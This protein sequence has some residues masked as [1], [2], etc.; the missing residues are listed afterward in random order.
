V[1]NFSGW[2]DE[3]YGPEGATTNFAGLVAAR[4]GE[5]NARTKLVMGPWVH[6]GQDESKAGERDFGP[7]APIDYDEM[8]L[9]WMDRYVRGMD[10]GVDREKPVRIFVVGENAWREEDSWPLARAHLQPYFL[11]AESAGARSGKLTASREKSLAGYTEFLSDP[12]H[13]LTNPYDNYGGHDYRALAGREDVLVFDTEPLPGDTEVTGPIRTEI[14]VSAD[15][16]DFDLWVR[17]LDVAPDGTAWNLMA[18]GNDVLRASDRNGALRPQL[19]TKGRIYRLTLDR[20]LTSNVFL[21]GHRIRVQISGAF[22]PDFTRNLQTGE[23][24]ITSSRMQ[25]GRIRV[26]HD[27]KHPS[28]I[29]LPLIPR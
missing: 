27:A 8:I 28:Q 19:L 11:S 16:P 21:K 18:P 4:R 2:Y 20:M 6:G 13:P 12:A 22:H 9:R 23:S 24:Q 29:L 26:H 5:K 7:T 17:L 1:L 10:N 14:Y 3:A 25:A 15:V